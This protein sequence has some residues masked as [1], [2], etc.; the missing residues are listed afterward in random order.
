MRSVRMTLWNTSKGVCQEHPGA[1][2]KVGVQESRIEVN[3]VHAHHSSIVQPPHS[4]RLRIRLRDA[5]R[6]YYPPK[7]CCGRL[8]ERRQLLLPV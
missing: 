1:A 3:V 5:E 6:L 7:R 8:R 4:S 2:V